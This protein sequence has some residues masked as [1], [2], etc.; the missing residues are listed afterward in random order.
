MKYLL[1]HEIAYFPHQ[2]ATKCKTFGIYNKVVN[3]DR[4]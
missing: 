3:Q 4:C 2:K 1:I